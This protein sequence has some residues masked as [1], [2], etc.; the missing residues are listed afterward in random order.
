MVGSVC[1]LIES[2][3]LF[4]RLGAAADC[5]LTTI[6]AVGHIAIVNCQRSA[7]IALMCAL[8]YVSRSISLNKMEL[9]AL[10]L[11]E[12]PDCLT[13]NEPIFSVFT[14]LIVHYLSLLPL[15]NR[16]NVYMRLL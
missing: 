10:S 11:R 12:Q 3:L 9:V 7:L 5:T 8:T 13:N 15:S 6:D 16:K 2:L 4:R 14:Y 1:C